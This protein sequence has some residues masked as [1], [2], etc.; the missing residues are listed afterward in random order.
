MLHVY[1]H[2][3]KQKFSVAIG[4]LYMSS[5]AIYM[6][7]DAIYM[8]EIYMSEDATNQLLYVCYT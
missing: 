1:T 3:I 7:S 5:D 8:S 6:S 4:M 2:M